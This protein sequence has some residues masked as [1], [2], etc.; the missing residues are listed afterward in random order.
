VSDPT[1]RGNR[2]RPPR[3]PSAEVD[4]LD[5]GEAP[6][7]AARRGKWL[8]EVRTTVWEG[9]T[10]SDLPPAGAEP[11]EPAEPKRQ[12]APYLSQTRAPSA[13]APA[14]R[15]AA[16]M[17]VAVPRPVTVSARAVAA[18][19]PASASRVARIVSVPEEDELEGRPTG[20]YQAVERELADE[21]PSR[22]P[23]MIEAPLQIKERVVEQISPDPRLVLL[24]QPGSKRAEQ[25][26]VL[27]LKL[28]EVSYLRVVALVPPTGGKDQGIAACNVALAFAEGSRT[29]VLLVD[30]NL[31]TPIVHDLFGLEP[32][33]TGLAEQVRQHRRSP[34][35]VWSVV[36]VTANLGLLPAGP[37]P[38]RNP[39]AVL[40]ADPIAE[41]FAEAR[42]SYDLIV[43]S[44]PPVLES[45]DVNILQDHVDGAVLVVRAGV[46]R[47]DSVAASLNRLSARKF[48]GSVLTD[49]RG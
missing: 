6:G 30:A 35:D 38:E 49:A 42:R 4:D 24:T 12:T 25:Y 22:P 23:L 15:P 31:R 34:R 13:A 44:P 39:S 33:W 16:P 18:E 21:R 1:R 19:R 41:L 10:L 29:R 43:V 14:A 20:G 11:A 7:P 37:E 28:R 36:G 3:D 9:N 27:A 45:A 46:T 5:P 26:R 17:D 48:L 2:A 8:D 40:S 47:R 32:G